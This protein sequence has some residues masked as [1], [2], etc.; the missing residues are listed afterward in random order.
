MRDDVMTFSL[1]DKT[2][3]HL[4]HLQNPQ[5]PKPVSLADM[6]LVL[7]LDVKRLVKTTAGK[8]TANGKGAGGKGKGSGHG[9]GAKGKG[10]KGKEFPGIGK[11]AS[12]IRPPAGN[13]GKGKG[14]GPGAKGKRSYADLF[15]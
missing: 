7:T 11:G 5:N 15:Y 14:K 6:R 1:S 8:G 2:I 10:G 12:S 13:H 4:M 9:H 3:L